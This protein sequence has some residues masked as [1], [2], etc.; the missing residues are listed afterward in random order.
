MDRYGEKKLYEGGLSVR[1]TLDP[2]LQVMARRA[3]VDGLIRFDQQL[4]FRGPVNRLNMAQAEWGRQLAAMPI[5]HDVTEW[6]LA[7]VLETSQAQARIGLRPT[8]QAGGELSADR[9]TGVIPLAQMT[10]ARAADGPRRGQPVRGADQVLA[11]GDV[12]YVEP[13]A[14]QRG[15]F[16]LRQI[17]EIQGGMVVMDPFT[18]RVLAMVGGF[19]FAE[20]VFNRAT[21]AFRQPGSSFKS[22]IYAAPS[23]TATRPPRSCST[24]PSSSIRAPASASGGPRTTPAASTA[25]PRCVS[26]SSARAT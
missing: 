20:S 22:F 5:L 14:N 6:R 1:T 19:S 3:M 10:W 24:R 11:V 16:A 2:R 18:G 23:T 8:R 9:Q 4:G 26:A 17:P 13:V 7:V 12:V 25:R 21:Q 15:I